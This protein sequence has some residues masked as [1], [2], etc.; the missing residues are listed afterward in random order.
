[1]RSSLTSS[2][3]LVGL[4]D[5]DGAVG[6]PGVGDDEEVDSLRAVI[7]QVVLDDVRLVADLERHREPHGA[8]G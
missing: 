5:L 2:G 1:M 7:T 3:A 4:E 8:A 6:G